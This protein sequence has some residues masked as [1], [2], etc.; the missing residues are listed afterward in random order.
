MIITVS[1]PGTNENSVKYTRTDGNTINYTRV[2]VIY[3]KLYRELTIIAVDCT[4][5]MLI[6]INYIQ[7]DDNYS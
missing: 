6:T 3:R 7:T 2:D 1:Y 5:L 4:K